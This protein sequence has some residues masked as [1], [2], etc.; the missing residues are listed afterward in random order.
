MKRYF[1]LFFMCLFSQI[2]A[3]AMDS[4]DEESTHSLSKHI[5]V[6]SNGS[7]TCSIMDPRGCRG[8][9]FEVQKTF[10]AL[11]GSP[12]DP[13]HKPRTMCIEVE[14]K[15]EIET[16]TETF[17]LEKERHSVLAELPIE[18]GDY[19]IRCNTRNG[20]FRCLEAFPTDDVV[21]PRIE[22]RDQDQ[23]WT[24]KSTREGYYTLSCVTRNGGVRYLEAF[25]RKNIIRPRIESRDQDQ[26]WSITPWSTQPAHSNIYRISCLTKN[27]GLRCLEAYPKDDLVRPSN[28]SF[29]QD[30]MWQFIS[31]QTIK[32]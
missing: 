18:E 19:R 1:L 21:R 26:E 12:F 15:V 20:G 29:D 10:V 13:R 27:G 22:L 32:D 31:W 3:W 6:R 5:G 11:S 30:Q 25:P 28:E 7:S 4:D 24:V 9:T 8:V 16:Q 2:P 17:L 14:L 23:K